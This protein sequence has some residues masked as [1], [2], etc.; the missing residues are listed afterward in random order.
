MRYGDDHAHQFADLRLPDGD[1]L[2]TL[3][4][5]HGGYWR[6]GYD[7]TQLDPIAEVMTRAGWATWNVEYRPIGDGSAWPDPMS[8]V[9]LAV[10]RLHR[11]RLASG[12]VLLGHSAGGHLAV[13]AASRT[14]HT[15]GGAPRVRPAGVVSLSGVLDLTRAADAPGSSVPVDEFAGGGPEQQPARFA[16]SDPTLLVPATCPVWAVHAADDQVVP[17]VQATSYVARARAAGA[18]AETVSVP[19]DHFTLIDPQAPS[20]PTIQKLVTRARA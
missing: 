20:F 9:A 7:L 19:G 13:W 15:P 11:E 6:P 10:D 14:G 8:D 1:P 17:L 2:G 3:V 5:L 4:L 12:V 18:R 16:V